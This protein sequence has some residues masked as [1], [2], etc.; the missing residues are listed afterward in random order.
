M[1]FLSG[2]V[3]IWETNGTSNIIVH[4]RTDDT[5]LRNYLNQVDG[6]TMRNESR[7]KW[8]GKLTHS[9]RWS[10]KNNFNEF[11]VV[12][13]ISN[14]SVFR[15]IST[16]T[17]VTQPHPRNDYGNQTNRNC[18]FYSKQRKFLNKRKIGSSLKK[19]SISW[20][21]HCYKNVKKIFFSWS[22]R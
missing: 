13:E 12:F 16:L 20:I 9:N 21:N 2:K 5:K 4:Q 17:K 11:M 10:R 3:L 22:D 19:N 1:F 14:Y 15:S 18:Y 8:N 6:Q 7:S